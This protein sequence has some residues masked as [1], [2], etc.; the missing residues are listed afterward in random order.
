MAITCTLGRD[1]IIKLLDAVYKKML[2]TPEGETFNV[3]QYINYLYNGFEKTQGRDVALQYIQQVPYV[4]GSVE[5][6]LGGD[7]KLNMPIEELREITRAFRNA[8]TGLSAIEKYLGLAPLTA[9]ELAAKA[10]FKSNNPTGTDVAP[11]DPDT[12]IEDTALKSRTILSGTGQEFL[13]LDPSKKTKT[14]VERLD[15]DKSRIYNTIS[16]IHRATF[17]FDT[18]LGNPVYQGQ[19][20]TLVPIAMNKIPSNQLTDESA[21]LYERMNSIIAQG[22]SDESVSKP[23]EVFFLVISDKQGN[24]L[25]FDNDGNITTKDKGKYVYQTLREVRKQS[26]GKYMVTNM[27]GKESKIITPKEEARLRAAEMGYPTP[28]DYKKGTGKTIEQFAQE[29]EAEQQ[30]EAKQ[31]YELRQKLIKGE[32][33]TLPVTGASQ[34]VS[35][36]FIKNLS[37]NELEVFYA[38]ETN[39]K[40]LTQLIAGNIQTLDTASYGFDRGETIIKLGTGID[41]IL[42]LDRADIQLDLATKI[43]E[44]LTSD[45]LTPTQKFDFYTQFYAKEIV[46]IPNKTRRH[47]VYFDKDTG[48]LTF[49]Y[50]KFTGQEVEVQDIK[51][52]PS[53]RLNLES[54]SAESFIPKILE[55]LFEKGKT[56]LKGAPYPAKFDYNQKL[57][58][59]GTYSDYE[60]GEFVEK[61]YIDFLRQQTA[62]I[63]LSKE[64]VPLFN[65]YIK[66]GLPDGISAQ[67]TDMEKDVVDTRSEVRKFKD[68]MVEVVLLAEPKSITA[69]V[70][71][72]RETRTK[73]KIPT[74]TLDVKIDGQEGIHKFYLSSKA[75]VGDRIYLEVKD[76]VDNGFLFQFVVKGFTEVEGRI[77]DMGSLA[78]RDFS[79]NEPV[80]EPIPVQTVTA[81]RTAEEENVEDLERFGKTTTEEEAKS[82]D[83]NL[84]NPQ[85]TAQPEDSSSISK[86]LDDFEFDRSAKLPNNVTPEQV[87]KAIEWW[88]NSPLSKYIK[89]FFAANI[90]NS[91]VYGKFVAAGARLI[92]DMNLDLDG[93]MGAILINPT[94]GGTMVDAYH[95]AWHVFSQLFLTKEQKQALYDEVRKLKPE[96]ANLTAREVEEMLAED[97]RSYALNPK[98]IKNR[99]KRN[100]LFRKILNFLKKLFRIKPTTADLMRGEELATEG[101][102]GELFQNLYFASKNPDL[103]NNYTPLI[104]NVVLDE[105][106]RGIE[107]VKN[108]TEDALNDIDSATVIESLDSLLG[109]V[110]DGA[111]KEKGALDASV[112]II[113]N[114][115][116][117]SKFFEFA[118]RRFLD[119]IEKI[120]NE[121]N[122]KPT[123][124]FNSFKTLQN[125]EDNAI[126]II[127]SSK[128][129]HKYIFL[130][131]QVE[132]FDN[133]NLDTK[134]G[135]RI[136]GELYKGK[137]EII[138]DYFSHKTIKAP[139]KNAADIIIVNSI[140]EA[141][142]QF[143]AYKVDELSSFT[144]IEQYPERTVNAF[145]VDYDQAFLLDNLRILRQATDNWEKVIKYYADKSAYNV[146]TRKVRIQETDPENDTT[147]EEAQVDPTKSQ[148]FDKGADV[149]LLEIADKEVVY[150]LKSLF[151]AT[152]NERGA[153]VYEKNRLGY[154]KLANYKKVWNA[155]VRATNGTKDPRLMY[156]KIVQAAS[157]Y[158]ELQQLIESRLPNPQLVGQA[159]TTGNVMRSFGITT[160][161]WSVFSLPRVPYM[162]LTVFRN[163]YE[164]FDW[165]GKPRISRSET[166]GLEVTNASTDIGNTIRK[167]EAHF[168]ARLDS[169]FTKR[170]QDN[171]TV[172]N[173]D[174]VIQDFSD[175]SGNFKNGTEFQFLNAIGFNLDDLKKIKDELS[176]PNNLKR[177]G[178]EFIF[179]TIKD[180]NDANKAGS[181]SDAARRVYNNFIK[182]PISG[183]KKGIEPGVIGLRDSFLLKEGSKQ[184]TQVDRII[185]LQNRYGSTASTF[186]VQNP[187]K[188]RVNEHVSDSTLTVIADGINNPG[189]GVIDINQEAKQTDM[190]R[191]G[192]TTEHLDPAVNPFADSS[193]A[194]KSMF[195]PDK[196][197]RQ[198]RSISVEMNAGTQTINTIISENGSLREGAVT[199]SNTTS[200]DKRGKFI[201]DIHTF[202][203]T[204]RIELMRP[205][206]KGSSFGWRLDGGIVTSAITKKDQHL[207]ADIDSFLPNTA[208]EADVIEGIILP[209]LSSEVKRINI[210][211]TTPEAKNYVGYNREFVD[212]K[213]FGQSFVYFDGILSKNLQNEIL[214]KVKDPGVKLLDYLKTDPELAKRIKAEIKAYFTTKTNE[215]YNYL[216]KAKFVDKTLMDRLKL[217]NLNTEQK[218]RV[219]M[220]A[221]MY[222]YWIHNVETSILFLGDI[223]QFDH[224]KQELHKRISGL[225]SN[226]PRIRTDIDAQTFSKVLGETS[227]AA[228]E[229]ITPIIYKGYAHTA[230]MKEV[231][232]DSIYADTI[233][234]GL[235]RDYERR[236]RTR[237]IPN[238]EAL[239]KERIEK[240][241]EKYTKAEI[242]EA[243]GQGYITFDAYRLFKT[244]QNKWSVA[245]E[246]LYQR[247]VAGEDISATEIIEMFPVYKLQNFG[248]VQGTVLP[249]TAMHKFA[250]M[251]L[252]PSMIKGTDFE[253]LHRQM[254]EQG[255]HYATFESGSKIG[256]VT[257][258]GKEADN[259]FEDTDQTIVKRNI[260]FTVNSINAGFLKE[261]ASV[262]SK[263]KGEVVFSTQLRKLILSGLYEQ[264]K[265][266]NDAYAPIVNKY[267]DTVDFYTELLKYD[268]LNEIEY[269]TD[270]KNLVGKP[271]KFLKLIRE[272]LERKDYPEHLLRQLQ[273]NV[274]GTLKGDLSYFIDRKT[275]EKTILS[276]V[277]KRFV[278][279]YVNG[280]P[281]VQV[282]STFSNGLITGGPRFQKPTAAERKKF[283]GTNNFPFY[284]VET[285]DLAAQFKGLSKE[286]LK[287]E[288]R[289]RK[290]VSYPTPAK[291]YI[292]KN[293]IEYLEDVIAGKKPSQTTYDK[294]TSAMKI[295]IA[296]QGD[297]VN[298]LNLKHIDGKP[299]ETRA[300]LNE[301]IK[302]EEWL[303]TDDNR[304]KITLTA[305]RIPVQGYNSMEFMEVYEFLDPA[306]SNLIMLPTEIVAKSG[307][308][309]DVDKLT[310]FFPNIDKNGNLYKA[311]VDNKDFI[312]E[313]NK[314]KDKEARKKFI[315]QQ[316]LATQ[317]QF[318]SSIRSILELPESYASLV[319][320]ND[321]YI[322]KDLADRL[323]DDV[324]DYDKFTKHNGEV[325]MSG[326]KK[327]LSP[328][329]TLE[330]LFNYSKHEEN[331]VGKAVLG[332]G[333][334][335]NAL[336]PLFDAAGGKMPL[337][338]KATKYVNGRYVVD[339]D[340]PADYKMR[341]DLRHNKIGDQISLSDL[342]SADGVDKISDVYSQA[343]NG[344]VDIEKDEWIFYI[345][346]NYEIAPTF[347]YLIKAGVPVK[348]AVYFVSQPMIREFAEQQ[349]LIG[350][351]YG[352]ILGVAPSASQFTRFQSARDIVNKYTAKYLYAIMGNPLI[353]P[354]DKFNV[355]FRPVDNYTEKAKPIRQNVTKAELSRE[356]AA[357]NINPLEIMRIYKIRDKEID[358]YLAPDLRNTQYYNAAV[359]ASS[360]AD[361]VDGNFSVDTMERIID[362][363]K[364]V[365]DLSPQ[366]IITEM[367]MFLHFYEIQKQLMGLSAMKRAGKSDTKTYG[368]FQEI[369]LA[370]VDVDALAEN[371]KIDQEFK[372]RFLDESVVA[373][374][375]DKSIITDVAAPMLDLV[376]NNITN[377]AIKNII[378]NRDISSFGVGTDGVIKFIDVYKDAIVTFL[379]QNYL[380]N[381]I[382]AQGN[383]IAVPQ[384]YRSEKVTN[385]KA[386]ESDVIYTQSGFTIN[387][388]NISR[389]YRTKA[390]LANSDASTAYK[391]REGLKPFNV[392]EDPFNNEEQYIRYVLERAFQKSK[393]LTGLQLNQVALMN[394]YNPNALS[395]NSE[396]SY[397]KMVLDL[398]DEFPA[399]KTEYPVL[400][401]LS[402]RAT[403][404]FYLLTLN[405]R[406]AIDGSTKSQYA[407]N[408]RAL[409]NPRIQKVKGD[410]NNRISA[411]FSLLPK[412]AV[413]QHGH[414]IT[415]FGLEQV[416][417]Q[418]TV[419]SA[420][421]DAGNLFKLNYWNANVLDLIFRKL[422]SQENNRRM[423]KNFLV[424]PT[425][426]TNPSNVRITPEE[427]FDPEDLGVTTK[428]DT[429][430][431]KS[432]TDDNQLFGLDISNQQNLEFQTGTINQV[433][434]F[435]EAAGI[436]QRLV[437]QI[438]GADGSVVQN[439]LAVAN[440]MEG[441][442]D[443]VDQMDKRPL[444]WNKLP[445]EAAHFWY[446]LLKADSPLKAA[447]WNAHEVSLK[448]NEL[449]RTQYGNLVSKPEDLTEE[450]IGQL[451]AEAI[452]R[453]ETKENTPEDKSFFTKFINFIKKLLGIYKQNPGKEDIFE[454]AAIKILSS[455]L[456]DLMSWQEYLELNNQVYPDTAITEA[457]IDPVDYAYFQDNLIITTDEEGNNLFAVANSPLFST[458]EEL[459]SWVY[460]N[461]SYAQDS[462]QVIQ[463]IEDQ[464]K[465]VDRL[466][467][468]T[469]K[470]KTRYLR[471][472]LD[473]LY[474]I[475]D[476]G[477]PSI[478][479]YL[480]NVESRF[481]TGDSLSLTK[482][483][484]PEERKDLETARDYQTITPTLKAIPQ[485]LTKYKKNPISL[486][487]KLKV[488]GVKKEELALLQNVIEAIKAENPNKKSITA[489]EFVNEAYVFLETNYMLGFANE[490]DHLDYMVSSTFEET[491]L[492]SGDPVRHQKISL[493]FND[494][495]YKRAPHFSLAPSAF[496]SLTAFPQG[497]SGKV[498]VLLHEIQNDQIETLREGTSRLKTLSNP[499]QKYVDEMTDVIK[500]AEAQVAKG[501]FEI[502]TN[503]PKYLNIFKSPVYQR[504]IDNRLKDDD[505]SYKQFRDLYQHDQVYLEQPSQYTDIIRRQQE[506]LDGLYTQTR[507]V[508][509]IRSTGG[510]EQFLS[511][512]DKQIIK[513]AIEDA[514]TT[515]GNVRQSFQFPEQVYK[516]MF[517]K[518]QKKFPAFD[519]AIFDTMFSQQYGGVIKPQ[520]QPR[521][522]RTQLN[523]SVNYFLKVVLPNAV[524][525]SLNRDIASKKQFVLSNI[526]N[527]NKAYFV[528]KMLKLT[529]DE[530][531]TLVNN[532]NYNYN[533][534]VRLRD[535]ASAI[536]L[537][538]RMA[539]APEETSSDVINKLKVESEELIK[540][541]TGL[542]ENQAEAI[543][544]AKIDLEKLLNVE[545]QYFMPLIHQVLQTHIKQYGKDTPLFFSGSDVTVLTQGNRRTAQIYA[546]PEEVKYSREEVDMIKY[547]L[548]YDQQLTLK[549]NDYNIVVKEDSV[550]GDPIPQDE[551]DFALK[552]L[553]EAKKDS[554]TNNDIISR[555]IQLTQGSPIAVGAIYTMLSK[556]PG[557]SLQYQ[558]KID[559]LRGS[560]GGYLVDLTN[561]NF[562]QPLLFGLDF[563]AQQKKENTYPRLTFA[564]SNIKKIMNG[565]KIITN[566]LNALST[567]SE[568]FT[569]GNGAIVKVKYLGE[570]TVNSKT[571]VVTITNNETG[572][573]TTRTL[574]QFAKAEGFKDAADFKKNNL[575][576][577]N[578]L[579]RGQARQVYQVQPVNNITSATKESISPEG[580]PEITEFNTYLE[581]NN[582]VFPKEFNPSNGRRYILNDNNL[583]D[584]VSPDGKTMYLRN[585]D[586]R[587]GKVESVPEVTVPVTEERKK[588][589]IRDIKEM[590][591]LMSLDLLMAED[592]YNIFQMMEDINNATTMN[593]V[594]KIEEIIRKYTC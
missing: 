13:T 289:G 29:I 582:N 409:G 157:N 432:E 333:A 431:D 200:L 55:V 233:R 411:V 361:K 389:D 70:V 365:N 417:P 329:T 567:D 100:T 525:N 576:S 297:F 586:L 109:E 96:Y 575:T 114:E 129:E 193:I 407:A 214:E 391:N 35:N 107:Q 487:E 27:Y 56:S 118:R 327:V 571:D 522:N 270:G 108:S 506:L 249:V 246:N 153:L 450:S 328:T 353:L 98:V 452:K 257:S 464:K 106:N 494:T 477:M 302:N 472:T 387:L 36:T 12:E 195:M 313:A 266:I 561:Y 394:V 551:M 439:A 379:Y 248:F 71:E 217:D 538:K 531:S 573:K 334:S 294:P 177:F 570:A 181:M 284:D 97:F 405:D 350:G 240:E 470:R 170:D 480:Q 243:D 505:F 304:Q 315:Q 344:W 291:A 91:D 383:I 325:N 485:I 441:T 523:T 384:E 547:K 184:S 180:L 364:S 271:D 375:K 585:M 486:S 363:K 501:G 578:F 560:T 339:T 218:E 66:F 152:R 206:S 272:N 250:L 160:S 133:L 396:Y 445:E 442:V 191:F 87:Q 373:S 474:S 448:N 468:K 213:T 424:T 469:Y 205:G 131:G 345:Q 331:H 25:Y 390:Y 261:A 15:R 64:G 95:E 461:T 5:A 457:S 188:N 467:N 78:E 491:Q 332:I 286:E 63:F 319:R 524:T 565:T 28:V 260:K 256:H 398:I 426:I 67:F 569:L 18:T 60:N 354:T 76:V 537:N 341:L 370:E 82:E 65:A 503:D 92:T 517:S 216:S 562:N 204:G 190:Y 201:Q 14:T 101:V 508:N 473:K 196:T 156:Q 443:I 435:L 349:R 123:I 406:D 42:K 519:R 301:M 221:F 39:G 34:G 137:I 568:F 259:V 72:V 247:I 534:L 300:R 581:E 352:A 591:K 253:L 438:L 48:V 544:A 4:I 429:G 141:K 451:I 436:E 252:I 552:A 3:D 122:L 20:L 482:K 226:G 241:V 462:K 305:V 105:L 121:L 258:N 548:A 227:Y 539:Q 532:I 26:D 40:T 62:D 115:S 408:I 23:S 254:M 84:T 303:D 128:G 518:I 163:Q 185:T 81:A 520:Y 273:T 197:K 186:S 410:A 11:K 583:Y 130:R 402:A 584:L 507:I 80:R 351:D 234:R 125:L 535:E 19:E 459:D 179:R 282:A 574:D 255:V 57:L 399:L 376:N 244:L 24:P 400:E 37:L 293:E 274:D 45:S 146:M 528:E 516:D 337:T 151:A 175:R 498:A 309:F 189:I 136:K 263:F 140:E 236:Y 413:Y 322:L 466:L 16:R 371:T 6:Q 143:D 556:V 386:L 268:L 320:P 342:Y 210:Y 90:V 53:Q 58:D 75:K 393:G 430:A 513:K 32:Q 33:F 7:L 526:A 38:T 238:K 232:R 580:N 41:M 111:F 359:F 144:D 145:E 536:A 514:N 314:I 529:R 242:K 422:T 51:D 381:S 117:K 22:T 1:N 366:E 458:I 162:Q 499:L 511:E 504:V 545:L 85:D 369:Y 178:I 52:N 124:P 546:G 290:A 102:A 86:L 397:T 73:D 192:T 208:G 299:I 374:L 148:K 543:E 495:Y 292:L 336:S 484:T 412:I 165:K 447:L 21:T 307:G 183:L 50:Y 318:I 10:N 321:T 154:K 343:M 49:E 433:S 360:K 563:S 392:S 330:P 279:Q 555:Q 488:D 94:T 296:L 43:A 423:F 276:I 554:Q 385:N 159:N 110:I 287:A 68:K 239:I 83:V 278:R 533:E 587:T 138:G 220:R 380:S 566:R 280:E 588:Q 311:P 264:G 326:G 126:A 444:A 463:Q 116:N 437:P 324:S 502:L 312:A 127:R 207:Y 251:P 161:F 476:K 149:N 515:T 219:L 493:R 372:R 593:Q 199:G 316:K 572:L 512:D 222:N 509:S 453:I 47:Q 335:E 489:E 479:M 174:Q 500:D 377:R 521:T 456:S 112:S 275:I 17:Q 267:E 460:A 421:T 8:D 135:E 483:L 530:Y 30:R 88:N 198:G 577:A 338:Y 455:D 262:N 481:A 194:L 388:E 549:M 510:F 171:V 277:E 269:N 283:L 61:N 557:V 288:L 594:E 212:G 230:I 147:D 382:D 475:Y 103:L 46:D 231:K 134:A 401:Q 298:L 265:L 104:S 340:N 490:L 527:R 317:N 139:N 541:A 492:P 497:K 478:P 224:K 378:A 79:A 164:T 132:D 404:D 150:I 237:N 229:D 295:G 454:V 592:G 209:Y 69:E 418:E 564:E 203:K 2:T 434:S 119:D 323:K 420:T 215:L 559:G 142:A 368:N 77:Y 449:Y 89:L 93:K 427:S 542:S 362:S 425:E 308:D 357:G 540:R 31:L 168:A 235:T 356:I 579:F 281:L 496:A 440:F 550:T 54:D 211:N 414:G 99:P 202:L 155:I 223:A 172:L 225:I 310:T 558:P 9:E 553:T 228:S 113:T 395:K 589:S 346:G 358:L 44:V 419:L 120:K 187:E 74:Y 285:V 166:E 471:K 169:K 59:R 347:L 245:Q 415:P 176:D 182:N 446:R 367:A 167:F 158:P 355:E 403:K 465:F 306:A 428:P 416:V 348:D 590:I 173:L